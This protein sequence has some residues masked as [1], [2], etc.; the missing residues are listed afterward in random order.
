MFP[1]SAGGFL[2][3]AP[4]GKSPISFSF[5]AYVYASKKPLPNPKSKYKP[6]FSSKS[7]LVLALTFTSLSILN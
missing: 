3:T 5:I 7:F 4:P 6:V 1:A 2:S